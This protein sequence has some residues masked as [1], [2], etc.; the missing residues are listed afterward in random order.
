MIGLLLH[1]PQADLFEA[2]NG[3]FDGANLWFSRSL[4]ELIEERQAV[5]ELVLAELTTEYL[6]VVLE[7][8]VVAVEYTHAEQLVADLL[9]WRVL[10]LLSC[11][12]LYG[13]LRIIR[14]PA[15]FEVDHDRL[16]DAVRDVVHFDVDYF[17]E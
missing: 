10:E 6:V 9:H 8:L 5:H 12:F 14:D 7:R 3:L 15:H 1:E 11:D 13:R 17:T 16:L 2:T 4:V